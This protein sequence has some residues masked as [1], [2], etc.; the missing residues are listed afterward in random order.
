MW[1]NMSYGWDPI[2]FAPRLRGS[3][4]SMPRESF[5]YL[6]MFILGSVAR[7]TPELLLA[8]SSPKTEVGWNLERFLT[9]AERYFPH[10]M[11]RWWTDESLYF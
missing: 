2:W 11:L 1:D 9:A 6:A 4:G 5:Y 8:V 10:L 3:I 7:Y